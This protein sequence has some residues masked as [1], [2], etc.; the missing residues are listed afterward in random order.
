MVTGKELTDRLGMHPTSIQKQGIGVETVLDREALIQF[1]ATRRKAAGQ[2]RVEKAALADS[3]YC[4]LTG[5]ERITPDPQNT[6]TVT[7]KAVE[8]MFQKREYN[9]ENLIAFPITSEKRETVYPQKTTVDLTTTEPRGKII[10][11]DANVK[12]IEKI[13]FLRSEGFMVAMLVLAILAQVLHTST[14]FYFVTPIPIDYIRIITAIVV[15]LAVDSAALVKTIRSGRHI[16]L[17][18]FA[19]VHFGINMSAHF[20]FASRFDEID[21]ATIQFWFDSALLSFAVS[22]AVYCYAEAFAIQ[23]PNADSNASQTQTMD[24]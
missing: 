15:G 11:P 9:G 13:H 22:Y 3:W 20:R 7:F 10:A 14:F 4:E 16:Y 6:A 24:T 5:E 17:V 19:V 18:I 12:P 2:W 8:P 21:T 23:K 1:L